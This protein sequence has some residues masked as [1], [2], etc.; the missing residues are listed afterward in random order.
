MPT[1]GLH[2]SVHTVLNALNGANS[3]SI[4]LG[5]YPFDFHMFIPFK[6]STRFESDEVK[7][8]WNNPG[9]RPRSFFWRG[10]M[11]WCV[12]GMSISVIMKLFQMVFSSLL[13]IIFSWVSVEE[14][15]YLNY[16]DLSP[17]Q[18]PVNTGLF[19]SPSG[20]SKLDCATTKTDTAKRRIS[21]GRESLQVYFCTRGLASSTARG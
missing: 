4:Y 9:R 2:C 8:W 14:D 6:K 20:I 10:S 17:T 18:M 15:E 3:S 16:S 12:K 11:D 13:R 19:I 7:R 21:V 5:Q 1:C